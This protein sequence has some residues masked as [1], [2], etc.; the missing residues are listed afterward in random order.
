MRP[1]TA[2]IIE[3]AL[4]VVGGGLVTL[5][6]ALVVADAYSTT[7]SFGWFADA[8]LSDQVFVPNAGAGIEPGL[9]LGVV[10]IASGV[11]MIAGWAG[12]RLARR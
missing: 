2:T 9:G 3:V 5:G 10:G 1:A 7:A 6:T 12:F 4:L 8:P 11:A